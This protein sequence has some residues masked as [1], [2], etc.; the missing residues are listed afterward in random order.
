MNWLDLIII[1]AV[2]LGIL[3]GFRKGLG[4]MLARVVGLVVALFVAALAARPVASWADSTWE[5]VAKL[6]SIL[7]R[8]L[9]LPHELATS[10]LITTP[11]GS[12]LERLQL[13]AVV[14]GLGPALERFLNDSLAPALARGSMTVGAFIHEGLARIL[15]VVAAFFVVFLVVR[16]VT[17]LAV[18]LVTAPLRIGGVDRL[19][20]AA[21]GGLERAA[22]LAIIL[23]VLAPWL[24]MPNLAFMNAAV[25]G[26]RY[27]PGL[28]AA[29]YRYSPF[30][31]GF[32]P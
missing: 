23:G 4:R 1:V 20:G 26:S 13:T 22:L 11:L 27:A 32:I 9:R 5:L 19:L 17:G 15:L 8:H 25:V 6:S 24:G 3:S 31:Y 29:F 21:F 12:I 10:D 18:T 7:S 16:S 28:I 2:T 30:I 14:P